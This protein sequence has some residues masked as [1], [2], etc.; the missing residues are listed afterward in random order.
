[1]SNSAWKPQ[2]SPQEITAACRS[3]AVPATSR[4]CRCCAAPTST[5]AGWRRTSRRRAT[6]CR[7]GSRRARAR[8]R[9][10]PRRRARGSGGDLRQR[11]DQRALRG[12]VIDDREPRARA[13]SRRRTPRRPRPPTHRVRH[14]RRAHHG[15]LLARGKHRRARHAA[16]AEIGDED[17]VAGANWNERR[18]ALA[19]VVVLSTNTRSSPG[20]PRNSPTASAACAQPRLAAGRRRRRRSRSARGAGSGSDAVRCRRGSPAAPRARGCGVTPTVP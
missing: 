10:G 2:S 12:D 9:P 16:V 19:P 3:A 13:E 8:R 1:M 5:C 7:A 4:G 11:Q 14:L 17:F 15:A 6:G 20:A 18:M